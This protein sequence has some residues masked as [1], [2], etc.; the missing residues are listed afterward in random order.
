MGTRPQG[1]GTERDRIQ[2]LVE[3]TVAWRESEASVKEYL[4][5]LKGNRVVSSVYNPWHITSPCVCVQCFGSSFAAP[6]I[7]LRVLGGALCHGETSES[8]RILREMAV[9]KVGCFGSCYSPAC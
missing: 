3:I 6:G 1:E 7:V 8:V 2:R 4:K 5:L 9:G